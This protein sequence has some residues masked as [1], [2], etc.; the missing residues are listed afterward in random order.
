MITLSLILCLSFLWFLALKELSYTELVASEIKNHYDLEFTQNEEIAVS[1]STMLTYED[2][3]VEN[4]NPLTGTLI[5]FDSNGR[6]INDLLKGVRTVE[7]HVKQEYLKNKYLIAPSM[8]VLYFFNSNVKSYNKDYVTKLVKEKKLYAQSDVDR[9]FYTRLLNWTANNRLNSVTEIYHDSFTGE[10][11]D[12]MYSPF[13]NLRDGHFMG[14]IYTD[15]SRSYNQN[16]ASSLIDGKKWVSLYLCFDKV[17]NGYCFYGRCQNAHLKNEIKT[18][19]NY[20]IV[21]GVDIFSLAFNNRIFFVFC[22][23]VFFVDIVFLMFYKRQNDYHYEKIYTDALTGVYNRRVLE[24]LSSDNYSFIILIDCNKFKEINDTFGHSVGDKALKHIVRSIIKN[25]R[26]EDIV[27][28]YGG[29][30]FVVIVKKN[31]KHE[32]LMAERI[33]ADIKESPLLI[34]NTV[35]PLSVSYGVSYVVSE[36]SDAIA[37]ADIEMFKQKKESV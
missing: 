19:K 8:G 11:V 33:S 2:N 18:S 26:E 27:L 21:G 31:G 17:G 25:I 20:L 7:K 12:T 37:D 14:Y 10:L 22:S 23:L 32:M 16:L 1:L 6:E 28:R 29:D 13:F 9:K 3:Y 34:D 35:I 5:R 36:L 4:E 24:N 15:I 30:E